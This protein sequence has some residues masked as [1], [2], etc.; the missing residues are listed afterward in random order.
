[1]SSA[2][3]KRYPPELCKRAVQVV[4]KSR[5]E[6]GSH[7]RSS[8]WATIEPVAQ[9]LLSWERCG[10]VDSGH[11]LRSSIGQWQLYRL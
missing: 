8:E 6:H 11:R 9:T 2:S 1:M 10:Q 5:H 3:P 7:E 4:A